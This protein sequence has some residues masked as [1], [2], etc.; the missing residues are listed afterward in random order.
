[1]IAD[2]FCIGIGNKGDN[3]Q[4]KSREHSGLSSEQTVLT[5]VIEEG[6]V[7]DWLSYKVLCKAIRATLR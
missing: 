6:V 1:M 2:A 7:W 5:P 3:E 4:C